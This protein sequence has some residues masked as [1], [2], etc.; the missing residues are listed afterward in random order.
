VGKNAANVAVVA[1]VRLQSASRWPMAFNDFRFPQVQQDLGLTVNEAELF[2]AAVPVVVRPE[3]QTHLEMG[4]EVALAINTEKARSEFIIAPVLLELRILIGDRLGLFSGV[5][6]EGDA[7]LGL[8]GNCDFILTTSGR[9]LVVV[10]PV[11]A[12]VEAKNDNLLS[13][14]GQCIASVVAA[15]MINDREGSIGRIVYGAVTTGSA[16]KFMQLD[17]AKLTID[18]REYSIDNV[19]KILGIFRDIVQPT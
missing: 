5:A 1:N 13:G 9:Q 4:T 10:A 19:G 15:R 7:E 2:D 17:C 6:I 14:L 3:F 16:W 12:I 18:R 8:N 11:V